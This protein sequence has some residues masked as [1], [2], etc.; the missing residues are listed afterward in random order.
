V[1]K[2]AGKWTLGRSRVGWAS[3][4]EIDCEKKR[5]RG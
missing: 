2:L 5:I 4:V 3:N 1:G